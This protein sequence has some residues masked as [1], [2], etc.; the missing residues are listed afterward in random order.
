MEIPIVRDI[1]KMKMYR[2]K[3]IRL[4]NFVVIVIGRVHS[5]KGY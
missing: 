1:L 2:I 4:H 5:L 3:A